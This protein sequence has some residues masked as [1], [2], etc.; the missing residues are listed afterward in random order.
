M[1][2]EGTVLALFTFLREAQRRRKPVA[3]DLFADGH[4]RTPF[5]TNHREVAQTLFAN[6]HV[7]GGGNSVPGP[8][9][10]EACLQA[11]DLLLFVTDFGL[12]HDDQRRAA[13]I[14]RTLTNQGVAVAF[15]CMFTD[16]YARAAGL[17]FVL[18][19]DINALADLT[20][21]TI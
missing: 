11:G 13:Q 19:P 17:P 16:H 21:T 1:N 6:Y 12:D 8:E 9:E 20:L 2:R 14:L 3:V 15:I 18:C 5:S 7:P 10:L 4:F